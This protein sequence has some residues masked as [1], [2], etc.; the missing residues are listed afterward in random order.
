MVGSR[1]SLANLS[2]ILVRLYVP[3]QYAFFLKGSHSRTTPQR[4]QDAMR[5]HLRAELRCASHVAF[6]RDDV[7]SRCEK[8]IPS[9]AA[10]PF[11]HL[12]VRVW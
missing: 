12:L 11:R 4:T 6:A 8:E 7:Y 2:G 5:V 3:E 9:Q 10:E 1:R